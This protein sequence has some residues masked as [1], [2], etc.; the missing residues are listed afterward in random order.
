[1]LVEAISDQWGWCPLADG[2]PGKLVWAVIK[3]LLQPM[4]HSPVSDESGDL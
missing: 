3:D 4:Q 2:T 1:M